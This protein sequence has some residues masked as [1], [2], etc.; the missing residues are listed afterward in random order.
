MPFNRNG[1]LTDGCNGLGYWSYGFEIY[2]FLT[3]M[4]TSPS[5]ISDSVMPFNR[6]GK[7]TEV[8]IR[9]GYSSYG[10]EIYAFLTVMASSP[11]CISDS[12]TVLDAF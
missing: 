12:V 10:F 3:V 9:L 5:C 4:A 2:A 1:Q 8:C 7:L 6:N 11:S